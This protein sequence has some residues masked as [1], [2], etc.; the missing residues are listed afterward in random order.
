[1]L[2]PQR[3]GFNVDTVT[4]PWERALHDGREINVPCGASMRPGHVDLRIECSK[5][6]VMWVE[7]SYT[8]LVA[9]QLCLCVR[10]AQSQHVSTRDEGYQY[11]VK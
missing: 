10:V 8:C 7:P 9:V 5:N 3:R 6:D 11:V 2:K 1:M 4:Y